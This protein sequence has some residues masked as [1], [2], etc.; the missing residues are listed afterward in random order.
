MVNLIR[1]VIAAGGTIRIEAMPSRTVSGRIEFKSLDTRAFGHI[2]AD[3]DTLHELA[4]NL[5]AEA[6]SKV[7][8]FRNIATT[9]AEEVLTQMSIDK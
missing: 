4:E 3:A 5:R 9:R 1:D 2:Q 7:E 8:R 6:I